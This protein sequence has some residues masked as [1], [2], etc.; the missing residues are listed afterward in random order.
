MIELKFKYESKDYQD[1]NRA[2]FGIARIMRETLKKSLIWLGIIS[3]I[4]AFEIITNTSFLN[5]D[6]QVIELSNFSKFVSFSIVFLLIFIFLIGSVFLV[7]YFLGGKKTA[8]LQKGVDPN[9]RIIIN[10]H[11]I[12]AYVGEFIRE[13][14]DWQIVKDVYN[15]KSF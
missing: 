11:G 5:S 4:I 15:T 8:D 7:I 12:D 6:N 13:T 1:F 14:Y 2:L 10:N 3:G 9:I